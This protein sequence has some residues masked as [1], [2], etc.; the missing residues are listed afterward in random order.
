MSPP[1]GEEGLKFWKFFVRRR[2]PFA[3][4]SSQPHGKGLAC[5][6]KRGG[7]VSL[8]PRLRPARSYDD[9]CGGRADWR[10]GLIVWL[11]SNRQKI[12]WYLFHLWKRYGKEAALTVESIKKKTAQVSGLFAIEINDYCSFFSKSSFRD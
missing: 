8:F 5:R 4:G 7:W 10:G 11:H 1:E 12:F 3:A 2:L 9:A 6:E